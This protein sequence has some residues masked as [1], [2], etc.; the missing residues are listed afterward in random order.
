MIVFLLVTG[1]ILW[2]GV[3]SQI[4]EGVY[5]A[6]LAFSTGFAMQTLYLWYRSRPEQKLLKIRDSVNH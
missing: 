2:V 4:A 1:V 6:W 3:V 5:I